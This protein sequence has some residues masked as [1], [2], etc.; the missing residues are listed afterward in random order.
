MVSLVGG[1]D[2]FVAFGAEAG[3]EAEAEATGLTLAAAC[4]GLVVDMVFM[5]YFAGARKGMM[6][7]NRTQPK[8]QRRNLYNKVCHASSTTIHIILSSQIY[9]IC[10]YNT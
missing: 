3:A 9:V 6:M 1:F 8:H 5:R 10:I 2:E 4:V 7:D